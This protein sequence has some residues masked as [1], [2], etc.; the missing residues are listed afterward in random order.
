MT[1]ACDEFRKAKSEKNRKLTSVRF[2]IM[3]ERR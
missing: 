3:T 2:N 1:I